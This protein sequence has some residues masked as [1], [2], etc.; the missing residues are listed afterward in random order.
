M[1]RSNEAV[2]KFYK[3]SQW[4]K[5]RQAYFNYRFGLCERCGMP[6]KIVHHKKY[7]SSSNIFN[8]EVTLNF[9]NLE[10]LCLNCHNNEHIAS[11]HFSNGE[12]VDDKKNIME[13]AG[14]FKG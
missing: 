10:L 6:G 14:I 5:V 2:A 7:I 1:Q 8:P 4:V 13:L 9:D 3:S 11:V 12:V